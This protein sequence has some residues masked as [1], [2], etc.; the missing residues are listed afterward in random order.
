MDIWPVCYGLPGD[1][2]RWIGLINFGHDVADDCTLWIAPGKGPV[3]FVD[4]KG[5]LRAVPPKYVTRRAGR[6]GIRLY[7]E[8]RLNGLDVRLFV[9]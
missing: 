9:L 8:H 3:S 1:K 4:D 6:I 2:R 7:G 5:R